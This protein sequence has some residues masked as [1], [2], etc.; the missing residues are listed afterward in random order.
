MEKHSVCTGSRPA[1]WV[2]GEF[3]G[4][5][6]SDEQWRKNKGGQRLEKWRERGGWKYLGVRKKIARRN[7]E[8]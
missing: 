1:G 3:G 6:G 7:V 5:E 4:P 8:G 2:C